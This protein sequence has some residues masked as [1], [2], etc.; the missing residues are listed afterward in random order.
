MMSRTHRVLLILALLI[1]NFLALQPANADDDDIGAVNRVYWNASK[2]YLNENFSLEQEVFFTK[3][4]GSAPGVNDYH[5]F[6]MQFCWE[7]LKTSLSLSST[8]S[9]CGFVGLGI[10]M[11]GSKIT[12]GAF[13]LTLW[14]GLDFQVSGDNRACE[15]RSPMAKIGVTQTYYTVCWMG[16]SLSPEVPYL[17]RVQGASGPTNA[18]EYWWSASLI[19][20]ATNESVTIGKIKNL[21]INPKS[22]L[23]DIQNV[24]F[25]RGSKAACDAVPVAD[26][27]ISSA[28]NAQGNRASFQSY[29]NDRCIRAE[30]YPDSQKSNFFQIR[31]GDS[32]PTKRDP[33]YKAIVNPTSSP[34]PSSSK[35][36][37]NTSQVVAAEK[38]AKPTFALVNFVGNKIDVNV[39]LGN[40]EGAAP[41]RIYLVAPK[42]GISSSKPMLGKIVGDSAS[43]ILEFDELLSGLSI[44]LEI[45]S[46]KDGVKSDPLVG[47]Y[48]VPEIKKLGQNTSV[49]VAP[50][51]F[52]SRV[53]GDSAVIT[54]DTS[55]RAG[56]LPSGVFFFSKSLGIPKSKAIEGELVGS[57]AIVELPLKISMLGK[58][59]PITVFLVNSKGES[60]PLNST[61][62]IPMPRNTI[63]APT[64]LPPSKAV[65]TI[66]CV[67]LNQTRAF[68]GKNCPPGWEK[69]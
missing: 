51:N 35:T 33:N 9:P 21:A 20:L 66:I 25:Y 59:Y 69:K 42:L 26:L 1:P 13:D 46:E 50:K 4:Q 24:L 58:K 62:S 56:A 54:V 15:K 22:E 30:V 36:P 18:D 47:S 43:W 31:F 2:T 45:V 3:I 7:A 6:H 67:R 16:V 12:G 61:L 17:I 41:D 14:D 28:R 48:K 10:N 32:E 49:P 38:P 11:N 39:N 53:I 23:Q 19:N 60:K 37:T 5:R 64:V 40:K 44:P 34:S 65:K 57:K 63:S 68:E 55:L 8:R 27:V 29:S 52:K